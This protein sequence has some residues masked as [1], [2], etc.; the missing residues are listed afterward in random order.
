MWLLF[1]EERK[2]S[3]SKQFNPTEMF[4]YHEKL[5]TTDVFVTMWYDK[6]EE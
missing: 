5:C 6:H 4:T 3:A 2:V 1:N